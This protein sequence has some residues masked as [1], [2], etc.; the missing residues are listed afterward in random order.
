[1][2]HFVAFRQ[3]VKGLFF[4]LSIIA[5]KVR[6]LV[7][8]HV[9]QKEAAWKAQQQFENIQSSLSAL[10]LSLELLRAVEAI[11]MERSKASSCDYF[12]VL[13]V[14]LVVCVSRLTCFVI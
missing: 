5:Q 11:R 4:S 8:S 10:T 7:A 3:D 2:D 12:I 14:I 6:D 13:K 1:M 9:D